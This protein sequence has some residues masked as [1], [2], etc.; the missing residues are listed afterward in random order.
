ML[1]ERKTVA[2]PY[3]SNEVWTVRLKMKTEFR[4]VENRLECGY[5]DKIR[6]RPLELGYA[7]YWSV[8]S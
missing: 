6:E 8:Q 2:K 7:S 1:L 3:R 4:E 5:D